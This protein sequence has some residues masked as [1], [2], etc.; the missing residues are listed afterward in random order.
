MTM[1]VAE[2]FHDTVFMVT[3]RRNPT[4]GY[5]TRF[6]LRRVDLATAVM[7]Q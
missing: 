2:A 7:T 3:E 6:G 1:S 4:F 5:G